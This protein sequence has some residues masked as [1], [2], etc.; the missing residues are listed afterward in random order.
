MEP[1]TNLV[2]IATA[3]GIAVY[4]A[5]CLDYFAT[6]KCGFSLQTVCRGAVLAALVIGVFLAIDFFSG[7]L[8][9]HN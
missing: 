2:T 1:S 6:D 5:W 4:A 3:G 7:K 8:S 9:R